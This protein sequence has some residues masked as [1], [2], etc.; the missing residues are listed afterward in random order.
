MNSRWLKQHL[1]QYTHHVHA[2][3]LQRLAGTGLVALA[4]ISVAQSNLLVVLQ[5]QI[6]FMLSAVLPGVIVEL[7][8]EERIAHALGDL[9]RNPI[10]D[11]AARLKAMHMRAEGY[12]AHWSPEGVSPWFWFEQAGYDYVHAGENLAIYFDD[13]DEVVTAWMESPLHRENILRDEYTE[14][15]VAA[16]EGEYKGY[17]TVYIVQLFGTPAVQP[18][19]AIVALAPQETPAPVTEPTVLAVEDTPVELEEELPTPQPIE[20]ELVEPEVFS[21]EPEVPTVEIVEDLSEPVEEEASTPVTAVPMGNGTAYVSDHVATSTGKLAN[22]PTAGYLAPESVGSPLVSAGDAR[23]F[24]QMLYVLLT[25]LVTGLV[26]ASIILA[27]KH[28]HH[29]QAVYGASLLVFTVAL[30]GMHAYF[31]HTVSAGL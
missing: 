21:V 8:N 1:A 9:R 20:E 13:S 18:P 7:T 4:L 19:P 29:T 23:N 31:T 28:L 2:S 25:I 6:D 16:I 5:K 12:F 27:E 3:R 11:E 22:S 15:G 10:L 14:I 30:V 24:L 26:V 17:D